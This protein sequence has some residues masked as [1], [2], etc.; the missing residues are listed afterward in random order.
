MKKI[1][2]W[3]LAIDVFLNGAEMVIEEQ[4]TMAGGGQV[5][6]YLESSCSN[7]DIDSLMNRAG[8]NWHDVAEPRLLC[9]NSSKG[10]LNHLKARGKNDLCPQHIFTPTVLFS[11]QVRSHIHYVVIY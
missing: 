8:Q 2:K 5:V 4:G 3:P 1:L 11:D 10:N 7:F 6:Q 9:N